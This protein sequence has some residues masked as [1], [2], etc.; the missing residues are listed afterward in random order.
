MKTNRYKYILILIGIVSLF[1]C[2]DYLKEEGYTETTGANLVSTEQ[3]METM[4]N[5]CYACLRLWYGKENAILLSEVGTDIYTGGNHYISSEF[6]TYSNSLNGS[7]APLEEY[8][9]YFYLALSTTN[10]ILDWLPQSVL[11]DKKKSIREAEVRFIRAL[12]LWHITEMWGEAPLYT[13]PIETKELT[14]TKSSVDDFYNQIFED[15]L[16]AEENM[17]KMTPEEIV[18]QEDGRVTIWAVR[19]MLARMYL[20]RKDYENAYK[21][22]NMVITEGG[23]EIAPSPDFLWNRTNEKERLIKEVIWSVIYAE[24]GEPE[25]YAIIRP[26][27]TVNDKTQYWPDRH[28]NNLH[29]NFLCYYQSKNSSV[30]ERS[31]EYGRAFVRFMPTL[32]LLDLYDESVDLRFLSHFR[33]VYRCNKENTQGYAVGDTFIYFSKYVIPQEVRNSVNYFIYDRDDMFDLE[34]GRFDSDR[35]FYFSLNKFLDPLRNDKEDAHSGRDV[36][37]F[38]LAEMYFI[39]AEAKLFTDGPAAAY[40]YLEEIA[41]NRAVGGDGATMLSA[42]GALSDGTGIDIDFILDEKGREFCGEFI[43]WFDLKRTGKLVERTRLHN[44][45]AASIQD[46]H[47]LRPIPQAE[48][49]AITNKTE[50]TQNP[51]YN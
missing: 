8:W 45:D 30:L 6:T 4:I 13:K 46:F 21:Y 2:E 51:G 49:D 18:E 41:N 37:V 17:S 43:R 38:R 26:P 25:N 20:Y 29:L 32:Y 9:K 42:Y 44:P 24:T 34:T 33:D 50:F 31:L 35:N 7:S 12:F 11:S 1:S 3:G 19:S 28:G 5:S 10:S 16:I 15:L 22:A 47:V 39:A 14:A 48:I 40:P 23:F 36:F 27:A